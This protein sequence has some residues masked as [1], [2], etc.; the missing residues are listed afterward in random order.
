MT[1][2]IK[3]PSSYYMEL[4]T[5]FPPRPITNEAELDATQERINFVLDKR[6]ITQDD[7]DYLKILGMLVYE[8]EEEHEPPMPTLKGVG[9]LKALM[10]ES[11][12]HINDLIPIFGDEVVVVEVLNSE[13]PLT[14]PQISQL[15]EFFHM[16]P[17]SF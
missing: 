13:R 12:L 8:Y 2:G 4:I 9:L 1:T 17:T 11:N 14:Q 6:K 16:P 5:E 10:E 3:T 7:R 15:A